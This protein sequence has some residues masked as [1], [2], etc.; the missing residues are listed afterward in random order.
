MLGQPV[1]ADGPQLVQTRRPLSAQQ[2]G[3]EGE[4]DGGTAKNEWEPDGHGAIVPDSAHVRNLITTAGE[5]S[6]AMSAFDYTG[7][8]PARDR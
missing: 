1:G 7:A 8:A 2:E 4:G 3:H 5:T 6:S